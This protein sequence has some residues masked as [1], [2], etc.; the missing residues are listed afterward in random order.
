MHLGQTAIMDRS[1][2]NLHYFKVF[3]LVVN[4]TIYHL[5]NFIVTLCSSPFILLFSKRISVILCVQCES[6][7]HISHLACS[8]AYC[9][10]FQMNYDVK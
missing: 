2:T 6:C 9:I 8:V 5:C 7:V 3:F 4:V 10:L 1:Q